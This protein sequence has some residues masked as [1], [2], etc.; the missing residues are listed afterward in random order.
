[1]SSEDEKERS[2]NFLKQKLKELDVEQTPLGDFNKAFDYYKN[3]WK[4]LTK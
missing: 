2:L 3:N 4:E 1:M